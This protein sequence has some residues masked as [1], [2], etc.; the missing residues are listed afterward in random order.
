MT[1][2]NIVN[3]GKA[4]AQNGKTKRRGAVFLCYN[5]AI[6]YK[7]GDYVYKLRAPSFPVDRELMI[8]TWT[9]LSRYSLPMEKV[10]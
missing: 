7:M 1:V 2:L 9:F 5:L 4:V 6:T 8:L 10:I 3:T